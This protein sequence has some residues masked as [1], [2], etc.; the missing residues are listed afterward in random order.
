MKEQQVLEDLLITN[1]VRGYS[2]PIPVDLLIDIFSRVCAKSIARFP[3]VSKFWESIFGS[4]Y[5]KELFLT[6]SVA[7]PRLLFT[8]KANKEL[9]VFSSPQPQSPDGI[10]SLVATP[11]KSFPKYFPTDI[12]TSH[13]GLVFLQHRRRKFRVI[14]N[15]VTGESITLPKLKG[16]SSYF[17]FDPI[18][19]HFKVLC[20]TQNTHWIFDIGDWK[21]SMADD[22]RPST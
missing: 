19:K 2:D 12:C 22:P 20:M 11:Y 14:C 17:G 9:Y 5:F 6:N 16:R 8:F 18:S 21:T 7:R 10:S 3:C 4:P 13:S 1:S 15:P